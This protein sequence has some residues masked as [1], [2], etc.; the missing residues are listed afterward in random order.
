MSTSPEPS[1]K[2]LTIL[3][4]PVLHLS[5]FGVQTCGGGVEGQFERLPQTLLPSGQVK[6]GWH[7]AEGW[8]IPERSETFLKNLST[9]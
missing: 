6:A 2:H 7:V 4:K 9:G 5:A 1:G 3:C 8:G